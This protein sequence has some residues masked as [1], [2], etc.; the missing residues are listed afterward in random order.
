MGNWILI[1]DDVVFMCMMIKDILM[2]NGY[3]V[4]VEVVDG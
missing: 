2:K 1:V 3:E 4:V